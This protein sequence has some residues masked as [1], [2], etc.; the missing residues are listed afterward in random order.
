MELN[1]TEIEFIYKKRRE[2]ELL[3]KRMEQH[4]KI[5][6]F[7]GITLYAVRIKVYFTIIAYCL[8]ALVGYKLRYERSIYEI[9][10]ILCMLLQHKAPKKEI[11]TRC[12]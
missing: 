12:D 11:L 5:K 10:N 8:I 4:L 2:V 7:W 3:F 6:A 1:A 9:L